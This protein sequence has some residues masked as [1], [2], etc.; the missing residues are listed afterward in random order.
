MVF[1]N[2]LLFLFNCCRWFICNIVYYVVNVF[3]FVYD[4]CRND[5]KYILW[6]MC[7]V[8]CY[9]VDWCNGVDFDC[10]II[11]FCIIYN[12]NVVD[13]RKNSEVLLDIMF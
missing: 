1:V 6:D 9:V 4:M 7:L 11:C 5:F 8:R 3:Y 13:V 2:C 12:I 10:V